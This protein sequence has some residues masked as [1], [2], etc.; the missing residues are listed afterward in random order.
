MKNE[1]E[2]GKEQEDELSDLSWSKIVD[3]VQKENSK[4]SDLVNS[5][6]LDLEEV[7]N[8]IK[9]L[10]TELSIL[11]FQEEKLIKAA[12]DIAKHLEKKLPLGVQ[13]DGYIIVISDSNLLIE[14]NVI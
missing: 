3:I 2:I 7:R 12:Q 6:A 1:I 14:K 10:K 4:A 9:R 13:R 8:G 5:C 11:E